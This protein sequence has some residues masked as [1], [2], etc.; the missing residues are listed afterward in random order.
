[1]WPY[2]GRH[3]L[4]LM[5]DHAQSRNHCCLAHFLSDRQ[6][7]FYYQYA[8]TSSRIQVSGTVPAGTYSVTITGLHGDHPAPSNDFTLTAAFTVSPA[9]GSPPVGSL[10]EQPSRSLAQV[11]SQLTRIAALQPSAPDSVRTSLPIPSML[12]KWSHGRPFGDIRYRDGNRL[13]GFPTMTPIR[14]L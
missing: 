11:S 14:S 7:W 3:G 9:T 13:S 12:S 6:F 8:P 1:M 10:P 4:A 2:T 5:P